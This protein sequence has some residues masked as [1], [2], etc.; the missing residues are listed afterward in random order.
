MACA[1][2]DIVRD[3]GEPYDGFI[4][5]YR[6]RL[7]VADRLRGEVESMNVD[8]LVVRP[9]RRL[10]ERWRAG[11][12]WKSLTS[13]DLEELAHELATLP[14]ELPTEEE[15][16]K[17]FDSRMRRLQLARLQGDGRFAKLAEQ[18]RKIAALLEEKKNIPIIRTEPR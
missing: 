3:A 12:A 16:A 15:D 7:D 18:L 4:D 1:A 8:N 9:Q 2:A 5:E 14:N 13:A 17:R 10:V 11:D 6:L